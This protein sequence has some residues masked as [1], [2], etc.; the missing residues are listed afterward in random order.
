MAQKE[1]S[2]RTAGNGMKR[3]DIGCGVGAMN[4]CRRVD[5]WV[6]AFWVLAFWVLA[7]WVLALWVF[8]VY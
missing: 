2:K 8:V 7:L 3:T 4:C 5:P 1:K 6:L